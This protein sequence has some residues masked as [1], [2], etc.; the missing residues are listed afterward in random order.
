LIRAVTPT[1]FGNVV[2]GVP[3]L[4]SVSQFNTSS[5]APTLSPSW[6]Y[7]YCAAVNWALR[8][9]TARKVAAERVNRQEEFLLDIAD[10]LRCKEFSKLADADK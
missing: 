10:F 6:T 5:Q 8:N 1:P 4:L 3:E 9:P 7:V 2:F